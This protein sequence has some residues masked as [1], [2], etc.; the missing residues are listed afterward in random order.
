MNCSPLL[1]RPR[2]WRTRAARLSGLATI[3]LAFAAS[4]ALAAT[5][6]HAA[7][8]TTTSVISPVPPSYWAGPLPGGQFCKDTVD[9]G[10]VVDHEY[11]DVTTFPDGTEILRFWGP[12]V[13]SFTNAS[14]EG[15]TIVRDE[16]GTTTTIV[17][18]NAT[19]TEWGTGKNFWA[20]GPQSQINTHEPGLV[21]T[22]GPVAITFN[23]IYATG[24]SLQGTQ[25]NG[26]ALLGA[27]TLS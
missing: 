16:S 14:P 17:Y 12:L 2:S 22:S 20:F 3:G 8:Q 1:P 9:V 7:T 26:C 21:F 6:A 23:G 11:E 27:G 13:L 4:S 18:S 25:V 5:Q 24:F 19:G 15:K 10:V